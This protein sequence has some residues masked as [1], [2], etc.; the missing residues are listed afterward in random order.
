MNLYRMEIKW[1]ITIRGIVQIMRNCDITWH[2]MSARRTNYSIRVI[3]RVQHYSGRHNGPP[4]VFDLSK[5]VFVED[6]GSTPP[7][8][9]L[10][11]SEIHV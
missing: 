2:G 1:E 4:D 3:V 8:V 9:G 7:G 5:V 6:A 11:A 10:E